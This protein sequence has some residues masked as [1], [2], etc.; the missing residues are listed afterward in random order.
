[1]FWK[2]SASDAVDKGL[3]SRYTPWKRPIRE[4]EPGPPLSHK[5]KGADDA[6]C[7]ASK[8]QKNMLVVSLRLIYP[9]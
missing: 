3:E 2:T 7:L 1:M 4:S 9:E 5:V 6:L 8:N